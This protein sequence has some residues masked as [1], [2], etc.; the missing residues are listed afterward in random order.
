MATLLGRRSTAKDKPRE[1]EPGGQMSFL[2][3][4]DELR[5]RIIRCV[6][7]VFVITVK[8]SLQMWPKLPT[9][10]GVILPAGIERK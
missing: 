9:D 8:S 10:E 7:F 1:E 2:D 5:R 4:L 3:H 6:I